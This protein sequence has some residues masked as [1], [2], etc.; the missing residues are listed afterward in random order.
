MYNLNTEIQFIFKR[1]EANVYFVD[2]Y[3]NKIRCWDITFSRHNWKFGDLYT[4]GLRWVSECEIIYCTTVLSQTKCASR[5]GSCDIRRSKRILFSRY[6]FANR[7]LQ[8]PDIQLNIL[9]FKQ[10]DCLKHTHIIRYSL[11]NKFQIYFFYY[12]LLYTYGEKSQIFVFLL[13]FN[14][15]L[16]FILFNRISRFI[17]TAILN[18]EFWSKIFFF[19]K[20]LM[21]KYLTSTGDY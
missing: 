16:N 12:Y 5:W 6:T 3:G 18:L 10:C 1:Y 15:F 4:Y 11:T 19:M 9:L 21:H 17:T 13:S 20:M 2:K 14:I 8:W 7:R